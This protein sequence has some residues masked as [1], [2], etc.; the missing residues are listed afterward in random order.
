MVNLSPKNEK[1]SLGLLFKGKNEEK[2]MVI[3]NIV[4]IDEKNA[5]AVVFAF[6]P[7]LKELYR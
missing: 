1:M 5:T 6:L 2:Y 7:V 3:R 4:Q